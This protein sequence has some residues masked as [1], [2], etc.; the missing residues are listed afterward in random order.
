MPVLQGDQ[1][2]GDIIGGILGTV[3]SFMQGQQQAKAQKAE[4][5]RQAAL[6]AQAVSEAMQRHAEEQ[7]RETTA[8]GE[9]GIQQGELGLRQQEQVEKEKQD[10]ATRLHQQTLDALAK[11]KAD[12]QKHHDAILEQQAEQKIRNAFTEGMARIHASTDSASIHANA[13]IASASIHAA[14]EVQSAGIREGG[15]MERLKYSTAH[16]K[17]A[18][19]AKAPTGLA[20][21]LRSVVTQTKQA[22]PDVTNAQL[23]A[24][25][26]QEHYPDSVINQVLP[27]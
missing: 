6:D 25:A 9:L 3:G 11:A 24:A 23:R 8:Q 16:P 14:A 10:A 4:Q 12:L 22:N 18:A 2:A 17:A 20:T 19:A 26:K 21:T 7:A 1:P 15:S 5:A 13:S 27:P